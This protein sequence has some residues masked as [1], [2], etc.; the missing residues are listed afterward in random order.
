MPEVTRGARVRKPAGERR[1]EIVAEAAGIALADGLERVTLRAVAERLG[2][3]PG[4]IS[5]YFP[6]AESLVVEAFAAAVTGD[7]ERHLGRGAAGDDAGPLARLARFLGSVG[8]EEG[9]AQARLWLN[10]RHLA[11]FSPA[12]AGA[13]EEQERLDQDR[14]AELVRAGV[15]AG[16]FRAADARAA[17][18]RIFIAV[19][20]F[21]AYANSAAIGDAAYASFVVD[22]SAWLLGLDPDELAAAVAAALDADDADVV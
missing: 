20:G 15:D 21:G 17:S 16:A 22:A 10:A 18:V 5:H 14:L 9:I 13:L 7:R 11:R 6:A 1:A 3:R 19:D 2:V 4:L 12:L 8:T